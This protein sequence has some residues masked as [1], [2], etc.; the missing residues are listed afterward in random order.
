MKDQIICTTCGTYYNSDKFPENC[1]I[2]SDDRQYIPAIG[3]TWT[4]P[5]DLYRKHSIKL[6][7]LQDRL[8][9][10]EINPS[11][12]IG[13]RALLILSESGNVLWDCIPML[14]EMT[15]EFI[16]S[17]GGLKAI[18]FSHP[19]FY[20]NMNEWAETFDCPIYIHNNDKDNIMLKGNNIILWKDK[21]LELWDEMKIICI[22]GHFP[23][24]SILH[25]PFLSS[26]GTIICG[27][28]LF[29]APSKKHFS[30]VY[31][32]PNRIPLPLS[33]IKRIKERFDEISFDSFYGY[34]KIQNLNSN[35]KK[36]FEDSMKRYFA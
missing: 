14:D 4:K 33:E 7:K 8:Y 18:G 6:N 28:T 25:V 15:I 36:I 29:L 35:V 16:K 32:S 20:S 24:S 17:K 2:C 31:S 3:Q 19:H 30:I 9:E 13:Q 34:Q 23:G 12:A 27:D 26:K 22:G 11:F 21:Q 10:F 5:A 1:R